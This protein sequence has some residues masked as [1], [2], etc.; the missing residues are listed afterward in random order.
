MDVEAHVV[1]DLFGLPDEVLPAFG[2][3]DL[4]AVQDADQDGFA[5][6]PHGLAQRRRQ[7]NAPLHVEAAVGRAAR[8]QLLSNITDKMRRAVD[9]DALMRITI[10]EVSRA[11]R[12][13][14]FPAPSRGSGSIS[15]CCVKAN[16]PSQGSIPSGWG[17]K[18]SCSAA[19][20]T[21]P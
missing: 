18:E 20:S 3:P 1:E 13:W 7:Q 4:E 14:N 15:A 9:M 12:A 8:E 10:E 6:E 21:R 16:F 19:P 17:S 2:C 11:V 5:L